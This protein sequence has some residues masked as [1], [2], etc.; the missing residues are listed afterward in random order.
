VNYPECL[1]YL[2]RLGDEVLTMKFGL[3]N[4]R[5]LLDA[6]GNPQRRFP[7]A[8]IA[9]TNGKGSVSALLSTILVRSG[10][11]AGLY[12][13]PHLVRVEERLA[14][15]NAIMPADRF[16]DCLSR[17][18][19]VVRS[20]P[21]TCHPT[22]FETLTALAFLYFAEEEVDFAVVEVGMGGRYD[23]T[24]VID[25]L[26][27]VITPVGIDHQQYL[28][29]R[30][31]DIAYQKA[32]IIRPGGMAL[33]APQA[34]EVRSV[35]EDEA[36]RQNAVLEI[37][38]ER[39]VTSQATNGGSYKFSF[40]DQVFQLDLFGRHQTSNAALAIRAAEI[41]REL[42]V[43]VEESG[44]REGVERTRIRARIEKLRENPALFLDGAHNAGAFEK[45]ADFVRDHTG[46]PR[47][48]VI[49]MMRDKDISQAAR[50]LAPLFDSV[51]LTRPNCARAADPVELARY[52]KK[53][54]EVGD[55]LEAVE[56]GSKGAQTTVVTGSFYL[57]GEVLRALEAG[58]RATIGR[59]P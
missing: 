7:S 39:D 22:F 14:V 43:P 17:I 8:L 59:C 41:L 34:P 28:G 46:R 20:L 4:I 31:E 56:V 13:S 16:A 42:K 36:R 45:L 38:D 24:N 49:G 12:T 40:H 35:L 30:L 29:Q 51:Y 21:L 32:G 47:S 9:G 33:A 26:L 11:R 55:P 48:L 54:Q 23:S 37:L 44:I 18:V 3:S 53:A 52:F 25:P 1:A 10:L 57:V 6:L 5:A 27:S 50:I 58:Q 19:P 2:N 15:D